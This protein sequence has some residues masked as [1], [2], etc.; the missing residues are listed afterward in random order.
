MMGEINTW[1][2]NKNLPVLILNRSGSQYLELMMK[3]LET[4]KLIYWYLLRDKNTVKNLE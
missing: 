2:T 3:E 4:G 1:R